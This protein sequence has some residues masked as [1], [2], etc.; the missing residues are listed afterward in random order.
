MEAW[1]VVMECRTQDP[2]KRLVHLVVGVDVGVVVH[3]VVEKRESG[4]IRIEYH[5]HTKPHA[6]R[7]GGRHFSPPLTTA[8]SSCTST[9]SQTI[10]WIPSTQNLHPH[11]SAARRRPYPQK[12]LGVEC[13]TCS[14]AKKLAGKQKY[15][16][17]STNQRRGRRIAPYI[18]KNRSARLQERIKSGRRRRE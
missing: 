9:T 16:P 8:Y 6:I 13:S 3:L 18:G 11:T 1:A 4:Q 7:C 15:N 17:P 12:R 2:L 5:Q 10:L 14:Q